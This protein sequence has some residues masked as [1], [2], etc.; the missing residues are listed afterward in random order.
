VLKPPLVVA[1]NGSALARRALEHALRLARPD[2]E[3]ILVRV[4]EVGLDLRD[5]S[6]VAECTEEDALASLHKLGLEAGRD[7][8]YRVRVG[9]PVREIVAVALEEKARLIVLVSHGRTGLSRWA[10][11][12]V[13]EHVVRQAPCPVWLALPSHPLLPVRRIL[14]PLDWSPEAEEAVPVARQYLEEAGELVLLTAATDLPE[15]P[16]GEPLERYARRYLD[17]LVDRLRQVGVRASS[18]LEPGPGVADAILRAAVAERA[19]MIVMASHGRSG[20]ARWLLGSVAEEVVRASPCPVLLL[21]P[22]CRPSV[23]AG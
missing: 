7:V 13:A 16:E 9:H 2:E 19:D 10:E 6:P 3:V 20:P 15:P 11:G 1:V 23:A 21:G 4:I 12:S 8:S 18:V 17:D 22:A 14:V 5:S